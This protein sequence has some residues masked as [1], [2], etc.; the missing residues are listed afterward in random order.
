[1]WGAL[2]GRVKHGAES[3]SGGE[4]QLPPNVALRLLTLVQLPS[5]AIRAE[6]L[7]TSLAA[8]PFVRTSSSI[9]A[10]LVE[11][12]RNGLMARERR[13]SLCMR[14]MVVRPP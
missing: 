3:N 4:H 8:R 14:L 13:A 5:N 9:P 1:M 10:A 11:G 7:P 6:H 12:P 2:L